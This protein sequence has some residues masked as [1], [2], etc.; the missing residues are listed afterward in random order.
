MTVA[1]ANGKRADGSHWQS[2]KQQCVRGHDLR[3]VVDGQ[4]NPNVRRHPVTD[5]RQCAACARLRARLMV[6][7]QTAAAWWQDHGAECRTCPRGRYCA[8]GR[9]IRQRVEARSRALTEQGFDSRMVSH[10]RRAGR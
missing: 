9:A 4:V 3:L 6:R 10:D 2:D 1:T 7:L 5:T 8:E